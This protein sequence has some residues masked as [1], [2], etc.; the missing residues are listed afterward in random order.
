MFWYVDRK[1]TA[2]RIGIANFPK[3]QQR[4]IIRRRPKLRVWQFHLFGISS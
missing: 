2:R 3:K 4:A 1:A